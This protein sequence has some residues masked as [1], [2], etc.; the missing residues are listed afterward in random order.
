VAQY[1]IYLGS[2]MGSVAYETHGFATILA[3]AN[4]FLNY[5][6][7]IGFRI[8][9][10]ATGKRCEWRVRKRYYKRMLVNGRRVKVR[11]NR[12]FTCGRRAIV[13][14]LIGKGDKKF[15]VHLC[16]EH[17]SQFLLNAVGYV[18]SM[19]TNVYEKVM[20]FVKEI[21]PLYDADFTGIE[22]VLVGGRLE[23]C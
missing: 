12:E 6:Y 22:H 20:Y 9:S 23:H 13:G 18:K 2:A 5:R 8:L 10:E 3:R 16:E 7:V 15:M 4:N 21:N 14:V 11:W 19:M 1:F 17:F